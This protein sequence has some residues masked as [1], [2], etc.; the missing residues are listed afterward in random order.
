[1]ENVDILIRNGKV[2][3]GFSGTCTTQTIAICGGKVVDA[4]SVTNAKE[5]VDAS[6]CIVTPGLIDSHVHFVT[7]SSELGVFMDY[8]CFP[9]GVTTVIDAG[10]SGFA[11]YKALRQ[12][13]GYVDTR[14]MALLNVASGGQVTRRYDENIDPACFDIGGI[15]SYF[16]KYPDQVIG[17]KM[18]TSKKLVGGLGVAPLKAAVQLAKNLGRPIAVHITNPPA[19]FSELIPVFQPGQIVT[20]IFHGEGYTLLENNGNINPVVLEARA[21]GVLFDDAHGVSNYSLAVARRAVEQGFLPDFISSDMGSGKAFTGRRVFSLP[22]VMSK[23]L[24]MG[25][26][27]RHIVERVTLNPARLIGK[28]R[29]LGS[30][31]AGTAADVAILRIVDK[32]IVFEDSLGGSLQGKKVFKTEMTIK[33]GK[34]VYRQIDF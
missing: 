14:I 10:T 7:L 4:S 6:G 28:E 24:A 27:E 21:N 25:I 29:E 20:H 32:D 12:A 17:L 23:Y 5:V 30:L 2:I 11:T 9:S 16:E 26:D 34:P 1:M 15:H 33:E 13:S 8:V 19:P 18:R 31:C 3:D 22:F